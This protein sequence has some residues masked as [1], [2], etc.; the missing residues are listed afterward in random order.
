MGKTLIKSWTISTTIYVCLVDIFYYFCYPINNKYLKINKYMYVSFI[1]VTISFMQIKLLNV[2]LKLR[3]G[4]FLCL[5]T[6][7]YDPLNSQAMCWC[8]KTVCCLILR[9]FLGRLVN[10]NEVVSHRVGK[11]MACICLTP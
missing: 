9:R 3:G 4:R 7:L 1:Q 6:T 5:L 8:C 2:K 11:E 10:E